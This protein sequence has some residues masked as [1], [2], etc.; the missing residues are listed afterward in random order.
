MSTGVDD[1]VPEEQESAGG[2]L[3]RKLKQSPLI[4]VGVAGFTVIIIYGLY[5]LKHRGNMNLSLHLI[6]TRVAAQ[7]CV[8]GAT[9]LG[10][11]YAMFKEYREKKATEREALRQ[12]ARHSTEE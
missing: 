1:W 12:N 7:A 2:R 11:T 10:T 6:H 8:V 4:P 3:Q 5:K 9:A